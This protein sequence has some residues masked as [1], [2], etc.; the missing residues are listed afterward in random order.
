MVNILKQFNEECGSTLKCALEK[1]YPEWARKEPK[2]TVP[3]NLDWGQSS[4]SIAHEIARARGKS[5]TEIAREICEAIEDGKGTLIANVREAAGYVNFSLNYATA[6]PLLFES[7]LSDEEHYGIEVVSKPTRITVEHTSANPSGPLT[8][9]HARNTLLGDALARMLM[10]RGHRVKTRFYVDDVGRQVSILAYGFK[11]LNMI[12]PVGKPDI[13][14]GRLYA[15][16]NCAVQLESL[17][18][19]LSL[20]PTGDQKIQ[21]QKDLDE[22]VGIAAELEASNK[23]LFSQ[24]VKAV[25]GRDDP[26]S[27]IQAVGRDYEKHE[28][29]VSRLIREVSELAL[30]GMRSTLAEMNVSF[31]HWDWESQLIWEG[32]VESVVDKIRRLPFARTEGSSLSLDVNA[33]VDAYSLK[34]KYR[35]SQNYEVPPLTLIR[36]DGTTLYPTRDIAYTLFKFADSDKVINVIASEQSLP[37]LQ[38]RLA[39]HAMGEVEISEK[40]V[41]YAYGLVELPGA[42][43]SK[44]RARFVALDDVIEQAKNKVKGTIAT[45]REEMSSDEMERISKSIAL[46]AIKFAMLNISSVKNLTFTWDRVL[47]L[48][49]NSAPFINYAYTRA[50]SILRKL[51]RAPSNIKFSALDHPLERLLIF[52]IAQLPLVFSEAIDQ[53]KPEELANYANV[54]AEK[55]HEYY[56]KVDVIHAEEGVKNERAML[57]KAIQI[58]LRNSMNLLGITLIERM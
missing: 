16:T 50:G 54:V 31:D 51:G 45:R 19:K 46:G 13:W 10:A 58:V 11:L 27:D 6:T 12:K 9:G 28:E 36:S 43:M 48:E 18:K 22:W 53:L 57:V 8:M 2:L 7:I 39:L 5:P 56:E 38:I 40:L 49:R 33:I 35:L 42:K 29:N 55:F 37:Q 32:S 23:E 4:S 30:D 21:L 34:E 1:T 24:V 3:P 14:L 26:E 20:N 52:K 25:Q 15:C 44:R 17:K 41:H 47:S